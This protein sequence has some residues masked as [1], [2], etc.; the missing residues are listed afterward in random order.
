MLAALESRFDDAEG[1]IRIT[2][3]DWVE[4]DLEVTLSITFHDDCETEQW[5]ISCKDVVEESLRSEWVVGLDVSPHSP[6]LKPFLEQDI[7]IMFSR[8]EIAQEALFGIVCSCCI[9]VM[10][11][12]DYIDRF[13]NGE[14]S[15]RGIC[16][17]SFG[18]LGRFPASLA[19]RILDALRDKPIQVNALAGITPK[20][21]N[22]SEHVPY[23][24]LQV[25]KIGQSYVI[26][27]RFDGRRR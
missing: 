11:R 7:P 9:E 24:Q 10:G 25:L 6:L 21:W 27:E 23:S 15:A 16:S 22:G 5:T 19:E 2:G 4:D 17:S 3:A 1:G 12:P 26:A 8:N 18:L 13:I 14:P 20:K